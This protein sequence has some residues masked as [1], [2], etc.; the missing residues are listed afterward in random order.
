MECRLLGE[1]SPDK[2]RNTVLFLLGMNVLLRAVEEHYYLRRPMS[3]ETL[4]LTFEPNSNGV[5]C[6]VYREDSCT[7]T[8]DGG[9]K[10]MRNERK[11]V[12]VYPNKTNIQRCPLRLVQK[13][14]SLCPKNGKKIQFLFAK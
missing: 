11:I 1:D 13:Y 7:K 5:K 10:D 14:L 8:H 2:L 6:L 4:Q 9:L 12:W 3:G